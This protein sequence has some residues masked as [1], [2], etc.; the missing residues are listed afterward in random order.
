MTHRRI[1]TRRLGVLTGVT[2]LLASAAL[3]LPTTA[4][5]QVYPPI[6]PAPSPTASPSVSP[7]PTATSSPSPGGQPPPPGCLVAAEAMPDRDTIIATGGTLVTITATPNSIVDL[8]A[9]TRPST[10]YRVVRSA[11]IGAS[12]STTVFLTPPAN[13]RIRA[14]QRGCA[15][16]RSMVINVRTALSLSAV[17]NGPRDYTF[18]GD[19]LPARPGGLIITLFRVTPSGQQIQTAQ[20]R[21]RADNGEWTINR[22]FTGNGRFGFVVR[23]GQDLQNAP[24]TSN[25]RSL[26]VF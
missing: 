8:Q 17:R 23:T 20:T 3:S 25:V 26:L 21:A 7:S 15:F 2:G 14:Q 1:T 13:T 18:T 12:G 10:A 9:Y 5:A 16:G 6:T 24:G 19:S 11:E 4:T 22:R